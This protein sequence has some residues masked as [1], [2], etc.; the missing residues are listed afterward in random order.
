MELS[1]NLG[2]VIRQLKALHDP[3]PISSALKMITETGFTLADVTPASYDDEVIAEYIR[4]GKEYGV[5][6]RQTHAPYNRYEQLPEE[7][8]IRRT[9]NNYAAAL[10]MGVGNVVVH[11]DNYDFSARKAYDPQ[12]AEEYNYRLYAPFVRRAE[13]DGLNI[14][15]ETVFEEHA[16]ARNGEDTRYTARMDE[17][18]SL[19]NR[20]ESPAAKFCWDFGHSKLAFARPEAEMQ[21][22]K[23]RLCATHTHDNNHGKDLH[24]LPYLGDTDWALQMGALK[25]A[26]YQGDLTFEFV[27]GSF[28]DTDHLRRFLTEAHLLGEHLISLFR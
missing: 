28:Y 13:K 21:K 3:A 6:Y 10:R 22:L 15:F 19:V 7:E 27:Y 20:F 26:D 25:K 14:C 1:L 18:L 5:T 11:G 4:C 17:L 9:E 16:F 8:F 2:Y 24:L 12:E 23:G